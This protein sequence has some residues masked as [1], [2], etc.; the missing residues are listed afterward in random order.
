MNTTYNPG[1]IPLAAPK[2]HLDVE[3]E[4]G[5]SDADN[6]A[7]DTTPTFTGT[8]EANSSVELFAGS[9]SIGTSTTDNSGNW[10][11]TVQS[12][13]ALADGTHSITAKATDSAGN[14]SA[15]STALSLTIDPI[16]GQSFNLDVDGDGKTTALGDGLMIIRNLIGP[17]FAGDALTNKAMSAESPYFGQDNASA[18]VTANIDALKPPDI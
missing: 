16:T 3:S 5:V 8:S 2:L 13:S 4:I 1:E 9:T 7:S 6:I 12:A 17:A 14:I 10:S 11:H 18:Q 15:A